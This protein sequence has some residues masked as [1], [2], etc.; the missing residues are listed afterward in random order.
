M[1]MGRK[2]VSYPLISSKLI[3]LRFEA[4][5]LNRSKI[6]NHPFPTPRLELPILGVQE[7]T[8]LFK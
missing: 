4:F 7:L 2:K 5:L 1:Y 8:N 6:F 3:R